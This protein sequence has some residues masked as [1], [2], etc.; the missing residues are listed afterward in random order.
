MII[1]EASTKKY[2]KPLRE[3]EVEYEIDETKCEI[4]K[5]KPCLN[6]CPVNAV[7]INSEND[8]I[9]INEKCFG[10][11]LCREICPYDAISME[12]KLAVPIR[13]NIPNINSKL[14]KACGACVL[15]CK[16]GAI[17]LT[18]SGSEQV[19]SEIDENK[20]VRC[21]YCFRSCPTDA[22]KYGEILPKT[23][24]G[25]RAIVIREKDCIGCMTCTKICP[26]RGAINVGKVNKL[27]NI[28]P[29]YCARC[30][31]CMNVC[32]SAA[33]RYSSRKRAFEQFNKLKFLENVST[34]IDND[35][36]KLSNE[37]VDIDTILLDLAKDLSGEY[38]EAFEIDITEI[39]L[40]KINSVIDPNI[41]LDYIKDFIDYFPPIRKIKFLEEKCIGCGECMEICPVNC[42]WLELPSLIHI[43]EECVFCG[44]CVSTC[45]VEAIEIQ[46]DFFETKTNDLES[47][48][49]FFTR[50]NIDGPRDGKFE[51]QNSK[52]QVCGI[53][54][55]QC[56]VNALSIK[57]DEIIVNQD[58]CISCRECESLCPL[59]AIN[60]NLK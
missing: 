41:F 58:L 2:N 4:C 46:E 34:I 59:N 31:E 1:I 20:C 8:M 7:S 33:I 51:I 54:A 50:R 43:E 12:T 47:D 45:P 10:C 35:I 49:I 9:N 40:D 21:G 36:K 28:N 32:P 55:N 39:V 24:S 60:I 29:S 18:A 52:C 3:V 23:V 13:E 44:N 11:V 5:D 14:C 37:I 26:S 48:K 16:T 42:I 38:D 30:E 56:P 6:V 57:N 15:S 27:P 22:I 17:H 53:C 19:H 25:G